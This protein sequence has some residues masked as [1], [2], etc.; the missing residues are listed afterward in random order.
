MLLAL[1]VLPGFKMSTLI[2]SFIITIRNRKKLHNNYYIMI[3]RFESWQYSTYR[4]LGSIKEV[5]TLYS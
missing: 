3:L 1:V 4:L 2:F 5:R